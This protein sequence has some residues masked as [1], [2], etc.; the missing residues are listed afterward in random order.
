VQTNLGAYIGGGREKEIA[1]GGELV[2]LGGGRIVEVCLWT[3][4]WFLREWSGSWF[5]MIIMWGEHHA[6]SFKAED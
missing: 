1:A 4:L 3:G 2:A 6:K 5:C